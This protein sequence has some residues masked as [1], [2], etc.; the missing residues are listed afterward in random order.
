M[1]GVGCH[2]VTH[3]SFHFRIKNNYGVNSVSSGFG[4]DCPIFVSLAQHVN[5]AMKRPLSFSFSD[6]MHGSGTGFAFSFGGVGIII[7]A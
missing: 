5:F 1:V 7:P 2:D 3:L 6:G 4:F